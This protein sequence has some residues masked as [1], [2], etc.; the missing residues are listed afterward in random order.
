MKGDAEDAGGD[1]SRTGGDLAATVVG[2]R[3]PG[4]GILVEV[5]V[6]GPPQQTVAASPAPPWIGP[7]RRGVR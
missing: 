7:L 2:M 4:E 3:P 1:A 6:P 5:Q